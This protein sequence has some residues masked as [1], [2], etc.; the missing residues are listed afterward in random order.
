MNFM[1]LFDPFNQKKLFSEEEY[2]KM[3]DG[4]GIPLCVYF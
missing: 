2:S 3:Y 1:F 4:F